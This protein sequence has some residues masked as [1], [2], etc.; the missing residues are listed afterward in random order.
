ML[1]WENGTI[2]LSESTPL[3]FWNATRHNPKTARRVDPLTAAHKY[4]VGD[5]PETLIGC[6]RKGFKLFWKWKSQTAGHGFLSW[7]VGT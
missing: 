7:F 3:G 4:K 1:V 5:Q 6:H 2:G